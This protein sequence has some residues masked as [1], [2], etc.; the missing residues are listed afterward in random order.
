MSNSCP[1][2]PP[3]WR[4]AVRKYLSATELSISDYFKLFEQTYKKYGSDPNA[5][6]TVLLSPH[7]IQWVS[8]DFLQR[9]KEYAAKFQTGVHTHLMGELIP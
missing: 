8:D 1:G 9:A 5:L 6:V 2:C 4:M 7:N 3:T